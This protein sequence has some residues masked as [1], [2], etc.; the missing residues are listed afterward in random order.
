MLGQIMK[1]LEL[2]KG[3]KFNFACC[4]ELP[5]PDIVDDADISRAWETVRENINIS[6]RESIG[7]YQLKKYKPWFDEGCS[8]L[9]DQWKQA[10]FQWL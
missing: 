9:L 4:L 3:S 2:R 6:A 1:Y 10:T 7:Y 8:K 5:N